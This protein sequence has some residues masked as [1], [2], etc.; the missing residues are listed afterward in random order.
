MKGYLIARIN[1][2]DP[3]KYENYK[4]LAPA[5]IAAFGGKYL[6]RGGAVETLEGIEESNRIVILEFDSMEIARQ[7]YH[8]EEYGLARAE[9]IGA[10]EGQYIITEGF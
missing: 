10:A 7:F 4:A 5:A 9:K 8:S 1:V 6:T 3:K 2:I